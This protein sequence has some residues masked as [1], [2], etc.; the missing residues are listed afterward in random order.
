[1]K[2]E[3]SQLMLER[4]RPESQ[5]WGHVFTVKSVFIYYRIVLCPRKG[6]GWRISALV[7]VID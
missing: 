3:F 1:M 5:E 7:Y 4:S 2:P 6:A